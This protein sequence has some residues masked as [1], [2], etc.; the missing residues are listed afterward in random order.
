MFKDTTQE[1]LKIFI[2]NH[3]QYL[4]LKQLSQ[5]LQNLEEASIDQR[6]RR[7]S[8][9]FEWIGKPKKVRVRPKLAEVVFF[10]QD[11]HCL[12]C[13]KQF[14]EGQL[15][16]SHISLEINDIDNYNNLAAICLD[17]AK[18][19]NEISE[20]TTI[21]ITMDEV[22]RYDGSKWEY[23]RVTIIKEEIHQKKAIEPEFYYVF[24]EDRDDSREWKHIASENNLESVLNSSIQDI[25]NYYG[26]MGWECIH[27]APPRLLDKDD[28]NDS[29]SE[30]FGEKTIMI[31]KRE[32]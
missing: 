2:K 14:P 20:L 13:H 3:F 7:D 17:C 1:I 16:V 31:F 29:L 5:Y 19:V 30:E 18:I 6:I 23:K 27:F 22:E 9:V 12:R 11:N 26:R 15:I 24:Q 8:E 25:M 21:P 28:G 10:K 32:T 4:T